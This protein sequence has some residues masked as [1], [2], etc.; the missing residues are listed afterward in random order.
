MGFDGHLLQAVARDQTAGP[1]AF[2]IL[3]PNPSCPRDFT[4]G[5]GGH[6]SLLRFEF[7]ICLRQRE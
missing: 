2:S 4:S 7:Y 6:P 1:A 3:P 5:P